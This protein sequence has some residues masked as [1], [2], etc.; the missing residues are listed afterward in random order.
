MQPVLLT[1]RHRLQVMEQLNRLLQPS[2]PLLILQPTMK[3]NL[4]LLMPPQTKLMM[5][6]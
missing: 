2:Q 3:L 6:S 4:N 1:L 5:Q